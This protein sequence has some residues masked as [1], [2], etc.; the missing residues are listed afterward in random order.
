MV[1]NQ[2]P[3]PPSAR[4]FEVYRRVKVERASTR[5]AAREAQVS[6]TRICQIVQRVAD[7]MTDALPTD[8]AEERREQRLSVAEQLAAEQLDFLGYEAVQAWR[9]SKGETTSVREVD[10]PGV[11]PSRVRLTRTSHGDPRY[12]MAAS[13]LALQ[14]A[15]L[16]I[17]VLKFGAN[18]TATNPLEVD[19]SIEPVEQGLR[20]E[21]TRNEEVVSDCEI[22]VC[23]EGGTSEQVL[24]HK[25]QRTVQTSKVG[26]EVWGVESER[27]E[28][29]APKDRPLTKQERKRR[30]KLAQLKRREAR[31]MAAV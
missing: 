14:G 4:D 15:K 1:S 2:Q 18:E 22:S 28:L 12:L 27:L 24:P 19:C 8:H 31:K 6:Q 17:S 25:M 20:E 9:A 5:Q 26:G 7:F 21:I 11:S 29:P 10:S 16:P 30:A 23:E 3:G 13:R